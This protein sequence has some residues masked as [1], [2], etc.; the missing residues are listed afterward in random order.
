MT[1]T[2]LK[3]SIVAGKNPP[4]NKINPY[5][6]T[7]IP[8]NGYP[9]RTMV[10]PKKNATVAFILCFWK[11]KLYVLLNPIMHVSPDIKRI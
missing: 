7:I 1:G 6:S 9:K 5:V 11:K 8:I 3:N 2:L 10:I 4:N